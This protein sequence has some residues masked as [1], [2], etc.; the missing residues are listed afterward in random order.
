MKTAHVNSNACLD[1]RPRRPEILK[2]AV[3][4]LQGGWRTVQTEM[5]ERLLPHIRQFV[6]VRSAM[7]GGG[8]VGVSLTGL[9]DNTRIGVIHLDRRERLRPFHPPSW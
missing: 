8:A 6:Q 9:L 2:E 3:E 4:P 5:V 1:A 7:A